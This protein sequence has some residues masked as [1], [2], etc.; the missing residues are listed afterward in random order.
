MHE[1]TCVVALRFIHIQHLFI[2]G[3][4]FVVSFKQDATSLLLKLDLEKRKLSSQTTLTGG[5]VSTLFNTDM[6][7]KP[8]TDTN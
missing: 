5:V 2:Y 1:V 6:P 7:K 3:L 4:M 8:Q